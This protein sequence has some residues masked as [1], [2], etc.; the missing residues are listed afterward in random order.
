MV[1]II[2]LLSERQCEGV[3]YVRYTKHGGCV[4]DQSNARYHQ[5]VSFNVVF[6]NEIMF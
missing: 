1:V 4:R 3:R 2:L 6:L 5:H